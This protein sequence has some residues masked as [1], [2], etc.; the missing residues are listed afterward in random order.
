VRDHRTITA[1]V[2]S[3]DAVPTRQSYEVF[4]YLSSQIGAHLAELDRVVETDVK[5][6]SELLREADVPAIGIT[7]AL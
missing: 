1:V 7:A 5:T 6:F 2:A 4:E 3:A